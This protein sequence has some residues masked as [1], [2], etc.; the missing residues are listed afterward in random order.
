MS[1]IF[2]SERSFRLW[3]LHVGHSRL[4]VRSGRNYDDDSENVDLVFDGVVWIQVPD[5][6]KGL[7][8]REVSGEVAESVLRNVWF[9]TQHVRVFELAS[10]GRTYF[11]AA[12]FLRIETNKR[13]PTES[14]F[15]NEEIPGP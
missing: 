14:V 1:E 3:E 7:V 8:I 9:E 15:R 5:W 2:S 6:L 12:S 4:L 11:V 10:Q 13:N